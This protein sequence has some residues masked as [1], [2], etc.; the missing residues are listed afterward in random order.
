MDPLTSLKIT[1]TVLRCS[2][3]TSDA[4]SGAAHA[5][6]KRAPTGFRWPHCVQTATG[7]RLERTPMGYNVTSSLD[8]ISR[9]PSLDGARFI[10]GVLQLKA[11]QDG[12]AKM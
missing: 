3:V 12:S 1:V 5:L 9:E 11:S 2:R 6:Q 8:G 10:Q 7:E 4:S